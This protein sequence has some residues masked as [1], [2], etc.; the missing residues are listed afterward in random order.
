LKTIFHLITTISRGGAEN[1]LLVLATE[2]VKSGFDVHVAYLKGEPELKTDFESSGVVVHSDLATAAFLFQP[3]IF[4]R[5][6]KN[7]NAI[8]HS[9]LPRAE[10]VALF[11]WAKFKL[12]TSRHNTEQFFPGAPKILSNLLSKMVEMRSVRIIAISNAVRDFLLEQGEVIRPIKIEVVHYGYNRHFNGLRRQADFAGKNMKLGTISRLNDQKDIPTMLR[13]FKKYKET[14]AGS[15]LSILG[16]GPLEVE[17]KA[18]TKTLKLE[19]SV[20]FSG[21]S[22]RIYDFLID[23]DVFVLTSK[24]EGFGMVLLEAMDAGVP[25]VA[26]GNSAILEVLGG[27]FPGLCTTGDSEDFLRKIIALT[28]TINRNVILEQQNNRLNIFSASLM[29]QRICEIYLI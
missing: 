23:L 19:D 22:S 15:T 20:T 7:Y 9:H 10:L 4:Q 1:Q 26:S 17:L 3:F 28:I 18:L 12:F 6:L 11:T 2:Q 21:R 24:Y 14:D 27:G 5:L 16:A 8:V 13:A 25:I 29:S